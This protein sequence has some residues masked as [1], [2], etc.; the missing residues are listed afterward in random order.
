[1]KDDQNYSEPELKK[2]YILKALK[3]R[4]QT[5]IDIGDVNGLRERMRIK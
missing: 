3:I 5:P 2:S 1:M 4:S